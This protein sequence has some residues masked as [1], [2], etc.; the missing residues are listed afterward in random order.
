MELSFEFEFYA[1]FYLPSTELF[2]LG[3]FK[4]YIS[5]TTF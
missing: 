2:P 4:N 1:L 3:R 5:F